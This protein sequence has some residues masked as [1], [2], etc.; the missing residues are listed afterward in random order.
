MNTQ[1]NKKQLS[2]N[3]V[4]NKHKQP[5]YIVL[6]SSG[7]YHVCQYAPTMNYAGRKDSDQYSLMLGVFID[8]PSHDLW[9]GPVKCYLNIGTTNQIHTLKNLTYEIVAKKQFMWDMEMPIGQRESETK[10]TKNFLPLI[11]FIRSL[12]AN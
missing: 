2:L 8:E 12:T 4:P 1:V 3:I 6:D 5:V 7:K 10:E 11:K 9:L